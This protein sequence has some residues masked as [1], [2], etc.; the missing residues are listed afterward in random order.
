MFQL[1][2]QET[3]SPIKRRN[4]LESM[5]RSDSEAE[6]KSNQISSLLNKPTKAQKVPG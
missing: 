1:Y 2:P 4:L 5:L 6:G 3:V